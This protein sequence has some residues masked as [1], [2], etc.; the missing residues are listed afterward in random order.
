M[1]NKN[2]TVLI[3]G[4]AGFIGSHTAEIFLKKKFNVIIFD[5]LS[6]GNLVN[7]KHLNRNKNFRFFKVDLLDIKKLKK[8]KKIIDN[9][10]YIIHFAGIGDIVPSISNPV[11]YFQNNVQGTINILNACNKK[12]LL[13]FVYAASS[14]CYGKA[15]APTDEKHEINPLYPYAMSKYQAEQICFHWGKVYKISVNSIRIF[16]AYG[17]RSRTTGAYGAVFGIFLKQILSN[18]PLTV[19]KNGK[20]KRDFVY[21]TDVA[22]AF[23]KAAIT[24][25]NNEIWNLGSGKPKSINYLIKLLKPKKVVWIP[26][27]PG[28]PKVTH[29]NI[30][31]IKNDLNWKPKITFEKG[32]SIILKNI[33]YWKNAPLWDKNKIKKETKLWFKYLK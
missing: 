20:Q 17:T 21:V 3:T 29:A 12:K 30:S 13:K 6:G 23:F 2:K 22:E 5:N 14:S 18:K 16:N 28:E 8:F 11:K 33:D 19:V 9:C 27:R 4:G 7:I 15:N 1:S 31:K 32:V 26:K 25:K 10:N 24:K